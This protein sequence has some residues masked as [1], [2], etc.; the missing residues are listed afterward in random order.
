MNGTL[1]KI[2]E[3]G[4]VPV[5]AVDDAKQAVPLA[6][7]LLRGGLDV[8]EITFRTDAAESAMRAIT[9][10][11]PEMLVGA[12]TVLT[13]EQLDRALKAGAKFIVTP[14]FNPEMVK[15]AISKD[16]LIIPGTA[17]GGE[18]EQAMSFGL[19][20][21]KFFPAEQN[22]G[23]E[24]LKALAAPYKNLNWLPTGGINERNLN[25]YLSFT[26]ILACGGTWM[27]KKSLIQDE[28]WDEIERRSRLAIRTMLDFSLVHVGI[29]CTDEAEAV[30]T[31][32]IF[33]TIFDLE[34]KPGNSS[35]FAGSVVECMKNPYLGRNGHIA[36]GTTNVDRAVA[37]LSRLGVEFDEETCKRDSM[38]N[39]KTIYLKGDFSGFAVHLVKK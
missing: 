11:V 28:R 17:T 13:K 10:N 12:G 35:V 19:E 29:N 37:H 5:I 31:A 16:A 9:E 27:V 39:I 26:Q 20:A 33:C 4:I 15:Y 34:Y 36:V 25:D 38:G 22:G 23:I 3:T 32:R 30:R 2:Y 8:A 1:K 6:Q 18:M 21:V 7:A 14:G 24:K